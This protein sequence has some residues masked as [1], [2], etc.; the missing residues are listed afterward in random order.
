MSDLRLVHSRLASL[1]AADGALT[2]RLQELLWTWAA[3]PML[4]WRGRVVRISITAEGVPSGPDLVRLLRDLAETAESPPRR[5]PY[6][7]AAGRW[8]APPARLRYLNPSQ[9]CSAA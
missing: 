1:V 4:A 3:L 9:S 2:P 6:S 7:K 5:D 8:L